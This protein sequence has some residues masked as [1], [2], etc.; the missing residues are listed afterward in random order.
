MINQNFGSNTLSFGLYLETNLRES[1]ESDPP[2][3]SHSD[4]ISNCGSRGRKKELLDE[5]FHPN[6]VIF[7]TAKDKGNR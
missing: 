5:Y 2:N 3:T 7:A 1:G 6:C 4:E